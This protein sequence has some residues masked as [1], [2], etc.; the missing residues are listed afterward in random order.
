MKQKQ[1]CY[2]RTIQLQIFSLSHIVISLLIFLV[3]KYQWAKPAVAQAH[4]KLMGKNNGL[5]L[6]FQLKMGQAHTSRI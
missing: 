3:E 6:Y 2:N 5:S 1:F 4:S